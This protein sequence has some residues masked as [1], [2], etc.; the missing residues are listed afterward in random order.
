M[1]AAKKRT[2]ATKT[3]EQGFNAA[4]IAV[5]DPTTGIMTMQCAVL[6]RFLAKV[7]RML[8][9][10]VLYGMQFMRICE[11]SVS[12]GLEGQGRHLHRAVLLPLGL[13]ARHCL[14]GI[15][16]TLCIHSTA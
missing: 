13:A 4:P 7:L 1:P 9:V 6:E 10:S 16:R 12:P 14:P 2:G 8:G 5:R 3:N 11:P 15:T